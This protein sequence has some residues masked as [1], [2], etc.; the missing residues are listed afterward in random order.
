MNVSLLVKPIV[1]RLPPFARVREADVEEPDNL[2][3]QLIDLAQRDL[4]ETLTYMR[5]SKHKPELT[6]LPMQV[7]APAPN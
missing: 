6:F 1:V 5:K 4:R 2:R 7:R 3:D